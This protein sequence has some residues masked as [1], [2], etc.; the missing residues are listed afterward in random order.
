MS[1]RAN[2]YGIKKNYRNKEIVCVRSIQNSIAP[3]HVSLCWC[4][5][6]VDFLCWSKVADVFNRFWCDVVMVMSASLI[7]RR[8]TVSMFYSQVKI[9]IL[10]IYNFSF[11]FDY[12]LGDESGHIHKRGLKIEI[13][14]PR[15]DFLI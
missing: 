8:I 11:S 3:N 14:E 1:F 10:G 5:D 4:I 6:A 12:Y 9:R 2:F 7:H 15:V 13:F